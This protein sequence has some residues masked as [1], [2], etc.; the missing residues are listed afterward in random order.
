MRLYH[1]TNA[2]FGLI[3]LALQRLKL[4]R[5]FEVNDPFEFRGF[6]LTDDRTRAAVELTREQFAPSHGM[7]CLS[8]TWEEPVMWSHY[9]DRHRGICL[10]FDADDEATVPVE[11]VAERLRLT[12]HDFQPPIPGEGVLSTLLGRKQIAWA[13][14]QEV[15]MFY[16]LRQ[17][18]AENGLFF[19]AFGR[20]LML[21]EVILGAACRIPAT[22][23]K[24]LVSAM[25]PDVV[26]ER[27]RLS[28]D[29]FA[30]ER[31]P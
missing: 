14:E 28:L 11:Y 10:G 30:I 24:R 2:E 8:R 19:H 5:V 18:T 21:R 4:A 1:Y 9:S 3:A 29:R 16:E 31:A 26:V 27:A 15:R 25:T 7:I 22:S 12:P 23:I 17:E 20:D 13:Y 6:D